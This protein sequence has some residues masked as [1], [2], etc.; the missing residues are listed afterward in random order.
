MHAPEAEGD[1]EEFRLQEELGNDE[2]ADLA[3]PANVAIP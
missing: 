1:G 2:A 3:D